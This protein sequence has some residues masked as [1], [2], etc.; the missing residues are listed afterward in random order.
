[1]NLVIVEDDSMTRSNL[2]LLLEGER[3]VNSLHVFPSSEAAIQSDCWAGADVLLTDIDLPGLGGDELIAWVSTE[4]PHVTSLAYTI[5][6]NRDTVF[7]AIRAGACGYLLKGISP[8]ELIESLEE[9]DRG[10][11]PMT[12]TI[13]RM[14]IHS[15][16]QEPAQK[17]V[18][19]LREKEILKL[20][21]SGLSYK[22]VA[23]RIG[24]SPHTVHTHIKNIYS[25][26]QAEGRE[27]AV[28]KARRLGWI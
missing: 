20:V 14:V 16:Q 23:C 28:R 12:A 8:R 11:A 10:G 5:H 3:S 2:K 9:L 18:L 13:A 15:L 6:E 25:K 7:S 21:E 4:H 26:V 17:S 22:E 27:D 24:I 19:S 1:M